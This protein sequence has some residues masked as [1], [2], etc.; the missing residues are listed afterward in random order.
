MNKI[1]VIGGAGFIGAAVTR[2]L[3]LDPKN[4][5]T[6]IG[7]SQLPKNKL[8]YPI[9][10]I[11]IDYKNINIDQILIG[12][13]CVIDLAYDAVPSSSYVDPLNDIQ[14]NV[15]FHIRLF[16]SAIKNKISKFIYVSSGGAI[17]G[18]QGEKSVKENASNNPVSPY[19]ITKLTIEKFGELFYRK[20][21]FP[22]IIVRPSNPYGAEQIGTVGQGFVSAVYNS[23]INKTELNIY[24]KEVVRDYIYIDDLAKA[25]VILL[26]RGKIG[27]IYNI[28][29]SKGLKNSDVVT[30]VIKNLKDTPLKVNFLEKRPFDV[31]YN[32]LD[33]NKIYNDTSWKPTISFEEGLSLMFKD[34]KND[35]RKI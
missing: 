11:N 25:I 26:D 31:S 9:K 8:T 13:D 5:I 3:S 6:V 7:R 22:I 14:N 27:S 30:L 33:I 19:G 16:E 28:G 4:I 18:D 17:Y 35:Y 15:S 34:L 2:I 24:G 21:N 1:L 29:S 32:V 12:F 10:Y 20:N 23:I